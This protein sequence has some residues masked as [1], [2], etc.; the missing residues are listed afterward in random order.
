[1]DCINEQIRTE[2]KYSCDVCVC[3]GG[4]AGISAA[5]AAARRGADTILLDRGFMLGG[6]ATAGIVTIYLPLCDGRGE[7]VCYGLAEEL[8]RLSIEHGAENRYPA[9]WLD[10]GSR[11]ERSRERFLVQFNAQFFAI[12]AERLLREA[13]VRILYGATVAAAYTESGKIRHIVIEGKGGR[14]GIEIKRGVVDATGDADVSKLAG[15]RTAAYTP[16]NVLAAW[17]YGYGNHDFR[18]Y[19]CGV[20]DI[21]DG[22][23]GDDVDM[24]RT[25]TGLDTAEISRMVIS[26]HTA[27]MKNL[28]EKRKQIP[29][30]VPTTI[31]TIPQLRMTRRLVGAYTQGISDNEGEHVTYENSVGLYPNW[32]KCG[33]V[34]ELPFTALYGNEVKNLAV[35]GRCISVT[36]DMW[37]ITRVIP[38]CAVS[39]EAAGAAVAM[40]DDLTA[41]DV[42]ALQDSLRGGGVRIHRTELTQHR[43]TE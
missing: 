9:A 34:Y 1:M 27:L 23:S 31:G 8:F 36:D 33:P 37:D 6:L 15:A 41:L 17:Y 43:K 7:Q 22:E 25:Y 26:S 11:E 16:G 5:L 30:L 42:R 38:V 29:D 18:L 21:D 28:L 40:G 39:G 32:R 20:H 3:G 10:G 19:M 13:G 35:A 14:E 2:V 24:S 12:S 4:V